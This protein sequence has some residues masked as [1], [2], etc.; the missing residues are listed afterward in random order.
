MK[1]L[2]KFVTKKKKKEKVK[3]KKKHY[4]KTNWF[5][6]SHVPFQI[7]IVN[8]NQFFLFNYFYY[9]FLFKKNWDVLK[10]MTKKL[11][12]CEYFNLNDISAYSVSFP[13]HLKQ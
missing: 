6:P 5:T 8:S 4:K 11:Q 2:L 7:H 10:R 13:V 1:Q 3:L 12:I 9:N